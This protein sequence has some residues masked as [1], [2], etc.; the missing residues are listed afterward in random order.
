[1]FR[2]VLL[3]SCAFIKCRFNKITRMEQLKM[4]I[5]EGFNEPSE[6]DAIK[7]NGKVFIYSYSDDDDFYKAGD[8]DV[9]FSTREEAD[10][11]HSEII[12]EFDIEKIR[13]YIEYMWN[14]NRLK[15]ILPDN[16]YRSFKEGQKSFCISYDGKN[17][18]KNALNGILNIDA[19]SFRLSDIDYVRYG[20]SWLSIVLKNG[21]EITPRTEIE[22]FIIESIF[23]ENNSGMYNKLISK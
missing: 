10:K 6:V 21:K 2:L 15:E 8:N 22:V 17:V 13:S 11:Y 1:M 20:K 14:E 4:F 18:L 16:I 7:K 9:F 12:S 3:V 5:V 23:G 19:V